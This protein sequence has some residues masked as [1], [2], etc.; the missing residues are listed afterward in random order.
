[1]NQKKG[2]AENG[3]TMQDMVDTIMAD[4]NRKIGW[5]YDDYIIILP[6]NYG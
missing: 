1:M 2:L 3:T 4:K 5:C 6:L